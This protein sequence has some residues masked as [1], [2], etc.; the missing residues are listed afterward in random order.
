MTPLLRAAVALGGIGVV[1][2][3]AWALRRASGEARERLVSAVALLVILLVPSIA[4]THYF[5]LLVPVGLLAWDL[6]PATTSPRA[7]RAG[8]LVALALTSRPLILDEIHLHRGPVTILVGPTL[9][10]LVAYALV[11][12]V[13]RAAS[14][15]AIHAGSPN[16]P[17]ASPFSAAASTAAAGSALQSGGTN[18]SPPHAVE[19]SQTP[20]SG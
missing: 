6:A 17:S 5:V 3:A 4:W 11:L 1:A 10:A 18:A 12:V 13:G 14:R 2:G 19:G 20:G 8:V 15:A 16:P 9:A 7:V